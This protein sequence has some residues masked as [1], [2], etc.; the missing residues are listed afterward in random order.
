MTG[1][2]WQRSISMKIVNNIEDYNNLLI[3]VRKLNSLSLS[4]S[5]FIGQDIINLTST[6]SLYYKE[7]D[8][9]I[10]FYKKAKNF[11]YLYYFLDSNK[12]FIFDSPNK[13]LLIELVDRVNLK[14]SQAHI[15]LWEEKGFSIYSENLEM[16][17]L[18]N[19][20]K[21]KYNFENNEY[22][23]DFAK[24]EEVGQI[25]DLWENSLDVISMPLPL[26]SNM[27]ELVLDK[28][29]IC[30]KNYDSKVVG[31]LQA[32]EK[33]GRCLLS[34]IV[35]HPNYRGQGLASDMI[36]FSVYSLGHGK[37]NL[38]VNKNN[39]GAIGLYNQIGFQET[40]KISIQLINKWR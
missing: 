18:V 28:H 40:N 19:N 29:I 13:N 17:I 4:N 23:I 5:L 31:A 24:K 11:D 8:N 14:R 20:S 6:K 27:E 33:F 32:N 1:L 30:I 25:L 15:N 34:H 2:F 22:T 3:Q 37:Y 16:E 35:I 12:E 38:W 36:K 7:I 26:K 21:S 39:T 9:G 10:L